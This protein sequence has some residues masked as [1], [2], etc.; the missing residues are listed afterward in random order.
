MD[1]GAHYYRCDLQ[2]HT[3]RDLRWTGK[4]AVTPEERRAYAGSLVAACR[5]KALA[6]IAVTDHH[7]LAL[8]DYVRKA[9]EGE[10]DGE[11]APLLPAQ[12]LVVFPGMELTL[13]IPCQ[14]L[15]I[16]DADFP[17]N[18]FQALLT[19]FRVVASADDQSSTAQVARL[20]HIHSLKELKEELDG[21]S[22]LKDR[23]II[24]PTSRT[25]G[26]SPCSAKAWRENILKCH[27]SVDS[28]TAACP[29]LGSG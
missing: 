11:G 24:F 19:A 4:P 23:Y 28:S 9:A 6:A 25:R 20:D 26:S 13:G 22:W 21:H 3:P 2:V 10:T 1:R 7:D 18:M 14:A 29:S 27:A 15:L 12:R 17:S 8:A 16:L 5:D